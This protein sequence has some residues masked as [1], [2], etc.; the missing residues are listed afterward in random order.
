MN[1]VVDLSPISAFFQLPPDVM[2]WRFMAYYGWMIIALM[3]LAAAK[4]MWLIKVQTNYLSGIKYVLLAIDIPRGN[5]QSPR[6]VENMLSYLAGGHGTIN[7]FEKYWEGKC[8]LYFSFEII[9]IDGY[10]QFI[11]RTPVDFRHLVESAVYSQYPD[12]EI[13]EV[14]D[15]TDSVP[16]KYPNEEYDVWGS[17]F[18]QSANQ[19]FPIKLYQEFEHN[20]GPDESYFKD[21]MASLM[22]LCSSLQR[23]EQLWFQTLVIPTGFDWVK[24]ADSEVDKIMGKKPTTSWANNA[25]D[26]IM[27]LVG[28]ISEA[29]YSLW[30]DIDTKEKEFKPLSMV[31]LR[32]KQ[33]KQVEALHNKIAKMG[34]YGKLRFVYVAKKEVFMPKK[35]VNGFVGFIKQFSALDLNGFKPDMSITATSTAYF[36]KVRR[37]NE[38]KTKIVNN[39][40]N[41]SAGSGRNPGIYNTEELATVWHFPLEATVKAPLIQK[42]PMKKAKPP[43]SLPSEDNAIAFQE[44]LE[45]IFSLEEKSAAV[46]ESTP[47]A[48]EVEPEIESGRPPVNLPFA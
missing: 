34:F 40:I 23:G 29:I 12:A 28:D 31:E 37:V 17:E 25:I 48:N 8:Q 33:K 36:A 46:V 41:R 26:K 35:V 9:S 30:G 39:Y 3:F 11:I 14:D 42:A 13:S 24:E 2:L 4:E 20:L 22:D 18:I 15:Y 32:P 16:K 5:E 44:S 43:M 27:E 7:F 10:T 6:A 47:P 21:P 38:R 1:I 19:M 45:P